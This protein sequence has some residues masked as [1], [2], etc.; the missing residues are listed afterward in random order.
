M[1]FMEDCLAKNLLVARLGS[2]TGWGG[3]V[4]GG[5]S[6]VLCK[7][8][9]VKGL[10]GIRKAGKTCYETMKLLERVSTKCKY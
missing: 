8:S 2:T 4:G 10:P 5:G 3:G 7:F 9:Y 1:F 6:R